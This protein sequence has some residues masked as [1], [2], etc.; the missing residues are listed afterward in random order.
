MYE[1][2][3]KQ[4]YLFGFLFYFIFFAIITGGFA[5][6]FYIITIPLAF[7]PYAEILWR[8]ASGVRPLRL[9]RE[10]E[11]LLPLFREVYEGAVKADPEL[12]K[13]IKI[14][15]RED[16]SIN[17]FAFGKETLVLTRGS[18]QLL[19]DECLKGLIAH[20]LGHFS[21][22]DTVASILTAIGNF[23]MTFIITK[24]YGVKVRFEKSKGLVM[25][26]FK[27]LCDAI[28]YL[29]YIIN[30]VGEVILKHISRERE[31]MAD[32]FA[33]KSGFG[34]ELAEVLIEIYDVSFTKPQSVTEQLK[35]TH[36]P[37][38]LRIEKLESAI[39]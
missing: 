24:L 7:T 16:M 9:R 27:T 19:S 5:I 1:T 22:Y 8:R 4:S 10:K 29:F 17:A 33:V 18:V 20:E 12:S 30:S 2:K 14:Y 39:N 31:Y 15:I 37:I 13:G 26:C 11:R 28:Y 21:S 35:N 3:S 25:N 38:T 32:G 23:P 36:P 34:K 6:F